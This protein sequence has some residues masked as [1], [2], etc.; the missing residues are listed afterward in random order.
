MA[1]AFSMPVWGGKVSCIMCEEA[2]AE[3]HEGQSFMSAEGTFDPQLVH[4]GSIPV[5]TT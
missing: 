1:L 5:S 4:E 2:C 3:E